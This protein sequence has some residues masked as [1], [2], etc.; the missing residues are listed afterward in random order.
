MDFYRSTNLT[1]LNPYNTPI[2]EY[3][4]IDL[5]KEL[6]DILWTE[7]RGMYLIYRKVRFHHGYPFKC[8]CWDAF[9]QEQDVD[10]TCDTCKG[11][12]YLFD[13]YIVRGYR[14]STQAFSGSPVMEDEGKKLN[15]FELFYFEHNF[16]SLQSGNNLDI[17]TTYDKIIEVEMDIDGAISS[18]LK[19]RIRYDI[20]STDAYRLDE[21]GRIEYYR[22]RT[23]AN[24]LG[25]YL[26]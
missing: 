23:K 18:P 3:G 4:E 26:V 11:L 1:H 17:P 7:K 2:S 24:P 22:M 16:I 9:T 25:S 8:T 5:R 6:H 21:R 19:Q 12:G 13:D 14:S 15:L 10:T 20:L